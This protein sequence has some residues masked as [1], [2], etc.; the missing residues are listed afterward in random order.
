MLLSHWK[1]GTHPIFSGDFAVAEG[2][3]VSFRTATIFL[4]FISRWVL[5]AA[6]T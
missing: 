5:N 3:W 6:M 2:R 4:T 1:I